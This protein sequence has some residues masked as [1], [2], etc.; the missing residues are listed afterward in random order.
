MKCVCL[1][2]YECDCFRGGW[3]FYLA[4]PARDFSYLFNLCP[5]PLLKEINCSLMW[6]NGYYTTARSCDTQK[7]YTEAGL[8]HTLK[9]HSQ[10]RCVCQATMPCHFQGQNENKTYGRFGNILSREI[11]MGNIK[12]LC[13]TLEVISN[14]VLVFFIEKYIKG[15]GHKVNLLVRI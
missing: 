7:V 10:T 1:Y 12:E 13:L 8:C 9:K 11:S 14:V 2:V 15:Q 4:F 6:F 3:V 5:R